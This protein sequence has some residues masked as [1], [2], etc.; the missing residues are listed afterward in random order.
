MAGPHFERDIRARVMI[1][2]NARP[3]HRRLRQKLAE[4][5]RW[6]EEHGPDEIVRGEGRLGIVTSGVSYMHVREAAPEASVLKLGLTYPLPL[7]KVRRF[8]ASVERCLVVEE[9]DPCLVEQFRAAGIAVEGKPEMFRFGELNVARVRQ[10]VAGDTSPEPAAVPGK[11]PV[12]CQGCPHRAVFEVLKNL[13]CIVSGDIGCYSLGALPPWEAMDLL[14]CM[15]ASIGMGLGLRH[16]LPPDEARRVVSVIGDSTFIHSGI[17]GLVEMV[18]NPPPGGHVVLILDNSTT[19]MTGLQEH[20]G[21]GRKLDHSQTGKIVLENLVRSLGIANVAVVDPVSAA[22]KF[23][24]VLVESLARNELSVIITR[25]TCLLA[26]GKIRRYERHKGGTA[27]SEGVINIVVAGLGGQG[28]LK[29]ADILADGRLRRRLGREAGRRPRHEPAGRIG[30]QRRPL[31]P[32]GL[33]PHGHLGR[34]RFPRGAGRRPGGAASRRAAARRDLLTP[35]VD[36]GRPAAQPPQRQRGPVRRAEPRN[37]PSSRGSGRR[38]SKPTSAK[39]FMPPT[40]RPSKSDARQNHDSYFPR[41]QTMTA[42]FHPASSPD[43][44]PASQL[45]QLQSQRL[46]EVVRR[47]YDRTEL[48]RKRFDAAGLRPE[49]VESIDDIARLPFTVKADLRDTYP[50]GLFASPMDEIV[51][52]HA[53]S[54]TTGKPIVVAYTRHDLD[55]WAEV[56]QRALV[57]FGLH[58]GDILQNS[59]GYGLF[60]GGLGLH[61]GG[62]RLGATVIPTSG[63]NTDRQIMVLKDFGVSAMS[64]TPSY[65]LHILDRAAEI[66]VDLRQLPLRAGIFGAEPWTDAM[67][68]HI[69]QAAGIKAYDIYGLTEIIGPGVGAECCCQDGIHIFEDHFYPEII[70]PDSGRPLPDGETGELVLTTLSK[71]AMPLLRFRTR[72]VTSLLAEPCPC[73]RTVRRIRRILHRTDDM[74]IIRGVNVFPSQIE[75]ALLN[76]DGALPHYQILLTRSRGLDRM[77]VQIEVNAELLS[78]RVGAMEELQARFAKQIEHV[79][80][81]HVMVTLAEPRTLPRSEGKL[82]RVIDQRNL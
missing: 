38:D 43:F 12:L 62:E 40:S 6:N 67:R 66:G 14:V 2:A 50:F 22:E 81:L 41:N 74:F 63:G 7:D 29:A 77:E 13:D 39:T 48:Y 46:C 79:I 19:A 51:R 10:I 32:A 71:Q 42:R 47:V 44:L 16:A 27:M 17:P 28:V 53:S 1:P 69:E 73:G 35:H 56:I 55:V 58:E 78:D 24:Q 70:D 37:W 65:F 30:P 4:L 33:Q 26:A 18:Y 64:C 21:T 52:L 76:V 61:Y 3:A 68:R 54:G 60:T 49:C 20:P 72:D 9:G 45:R 57:S 8:A 15:G 25:R 80:G 5:A 75:T 11:P 59:Y 23:Q 82:R 31:R 34:G 36:C